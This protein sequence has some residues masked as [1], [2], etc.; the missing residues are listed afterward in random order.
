MGISAYHLVRRNKPD[1]FQ[2]SFQIAAVVGMISIV[3]VIL[4]GH[5]QAQ[6][7]VES[8]PMKMAA[9]EALWESEDPASFSVLT[10]GDLS[11]RK[12]VFSIR[13][14]RLLSL[15]AYNQLDGE[16]KGIYDLQAEYV[17]QY[18]PGSYIPPIAVTYWSFRIMVGAGFA[19]FFMGLYALFLVM[20]GVYDQRT[21]I[22]SLF[23][24]AIL[25]PY[26]ANTA[27]W[28]MTEL[29]RAP[30]VVFGLMKIEEGLSNMVSGGMVLTSLIFF[31]LV[32]GVLMAAD[33]YLLT[34]FAKR[35]PSVSPSEAVDILPEG[36]LSM[37]AAQD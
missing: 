2:R 27:G 32:Y 8:Q 12:D 35:G 16:V 1:F 26:L 22:L 24:W 36:D 15:L 5:D 21:K 31:T 37:M 11:Q 19:L 23:T 29:G 20:S 13:I 25:I 28:L 34:K 10:I 17:Q 6:H 18:G 9:A 4:G 14:P 7:M 33:V 3:L 30:W